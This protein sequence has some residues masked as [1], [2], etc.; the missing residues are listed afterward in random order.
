M[1]ADDPLQLDL[2]DQSCK[3]ASLERTMDE[4]I[5]KYGKGVIGRAADLGNARTIT[6]T[7]PTLDFIDTVTEP[8]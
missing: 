8:D 6:D 3:P 1:R 2:F 7:T 4:C 5:K